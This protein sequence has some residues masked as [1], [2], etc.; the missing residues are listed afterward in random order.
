M[1]QSV[2]DGP[3]HKR[4]GSS[5]SVPWGT[6]QSLQ[7][8][9]WICSL[10]WQKES[11]CLSAEISWRTLVTKESWVSFIECFIYHFCA[12]IT[13]SV[14]KKCL[15][16][17]NIEVDF[18]YDWRTG[19][20][21]MHGN[22][23]HFCFSG[24]ITFIALNPFM[25]PPPSKPPKF[26]VAYNVAVIAMW[27]E[28]MVTGILWYFLWDMILHELTKWLHQ[29]CIEIMLESHGTCLEN[30]TSLCFAGKGPRRNQICVHVCPSVCL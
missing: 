6:H 5:A 22:F 14:V 16:R 11:S 28:M 18:R 15:G 13:D 17:Y 2:Q 10:D 21:H 30:L 23:A 29:D 26:D 25:P 7:I 20:G 19:N 8:S 4:K 27:R 9:L 3:R 12:Q 1:S 24:R